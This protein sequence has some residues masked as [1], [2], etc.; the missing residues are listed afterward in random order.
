MRPISAAITAAHDFSEV[1]KI[2][3]EERLAIMARAAE[4]VE[5]HAA[6]LAEVITRESGKPSPSPREGPGDG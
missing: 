3:P 6:V 5:K 2:P 4:L 1:D